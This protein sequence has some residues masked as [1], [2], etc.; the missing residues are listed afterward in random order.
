MNSKY[1]KKIK[2]FFH[3]GNRRFKD[4]N[5]FLEKAKASGFEFVPLK[6]MRKE[7]KPH[8]RLIG[9]RHD[10]D[11]E[12]N[13]ALKI[14]KI[15]HDAGIQATYFVR[16]TAR[17]FY[18]DMKSNNFNNT[19]IKKLLYIQNTLGHE[20]G[21]HTDLMPVEMIYKKDPVIFVN[22]LVDLMRNN[23]IHIVG[24]APHGNLFRHIYRKKYIGENKP[25]FSNLFADPYAEIDLSILNVDY[26][27]YSLEHD[28]YYS[29]SRFLNNKRWDFSFLED[30]FFNNNGRTIILT[31]TIHWAPSKYYYFTVNFMFTVRY[32]FSYV[33][34][35]LKYR[36]H[37]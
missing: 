6:E 27:A 19:L 15:E 12:L 10:V 28:N 2:R 4:Y 25:A 24:I 22:E 11:S 3:F 23:G 33:N 26:E 35:Y 14:A 20:I 17:Y 31:H 16:H 36:R 34:E 13:H 8:E 7:K 30:D 32:L 1:L 21:L 37:K 29:D 18:S 9:L 5:T